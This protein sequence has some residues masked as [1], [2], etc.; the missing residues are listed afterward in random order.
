MWLRGQCIPCALVLG[1]FVSGV[2]A[3]P[4]GTGWRK[5]WQDGFDGPGLD[6]SKWSADYPWGGVLDHQA[7]M[8]PEQVGIGDGK[9]TLTAVR[10]HHPD[11]PPFFINDG[12]KLPLDFTSGAVHTKGKFSTNGGYVEARIRVPATVGTWPAFWMLPADGGWPPEIDIMELPVARSADVR[13]THFTYHY[14]ADAANEQSIGGQWVGP[15]FSSGY[16][17]FGMTWSRTSASWYVD[18]QLVRRIS[19][20]AFAQAQEKMYI[21]LNLGV[22]G[23]PGTP[24]ADAVFPATMRVD[25]VRVYRYDGTSSGNAHAFATVPEPHSIS[26]LAVA[27]AGCLSGRRRARG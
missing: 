11:A 26:M 23:W 7:F 18:D 4:P 3:S 22:G 21:L 13:R 9:L 14:G 10:K 20:P 5:V 24:P 25:W 1:L 15:N 2:V 8:A 19:N 27:L 12:E 16:H 6:L 17:T